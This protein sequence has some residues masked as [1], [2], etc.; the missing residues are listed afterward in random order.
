[1]GTGRAILGRTS[2]EY[3]D[4]PELARCPSGASE[5]SFIHRNPGASIMRFVL[6]NPRLFYSKTAMVFVL[7]FALIPLLQWKSDLPALAYAGSM[8]VLHVFILGIYLYRVRFRDLDPDKRSLIARV[9][10][11]AITTYLLSTT[12]S[13]SAES[14][15]AQLALQMLAVSLVHMGI[16]A[17][18]MVRAVPVTASEP[19]E[20]VTSLR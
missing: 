14:S 4:S 10:G 2:Q 5:E 8:V 7:S 20:A 9:L 6:L 13:F 19:V 15:T 3:A 12:S 11:L 16:L 18:L 17:L 1:M